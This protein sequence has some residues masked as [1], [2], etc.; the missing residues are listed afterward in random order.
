ML[1]LLIY[2]SRLP[3]IDT[4]QEDEVTSIANTNKTSILQFP[5][6]IIG[7]FTLF[8]YVGVEVIAVDTIFGYA[9]SQGIGFARAKFFSSFTIFNML[10]G[11]VIGIICIPRFLQQSQA[12]RLSAYA[13]ILLTLAAMITQGTTSVVFIGLL[14]LAN[15]LIWPSIWPL[16]LNG[17]GRFTKVGSSFLIMAIG[18]GAMLPLLYGKLAQSISPH[19]GYWMVLPIYLAI[20]YYGIAGHRLKN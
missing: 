12:L 19:A 14:G 17:L 1:A 9:Q 11:Y 4:D 6:L 8:L 15:S 5:H 18:G 3:E 13:G 2:L 10:I 7:V 16:A 20:L